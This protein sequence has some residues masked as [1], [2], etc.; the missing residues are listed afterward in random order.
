MQSEEK[1]MIMRVIQ[2]YIR[3]GDASDAEVKVTSL[4]KGK[5]SY[6]E[7]IGED[8]RS[9]MLDE[10][11]V[12]SKTIWAGYSSRSGTVYLSII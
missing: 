9:V 8:G 4:P 10:Y 11:H 1:T 12:D 5:T 2:N 6:V 7:Q 3:T